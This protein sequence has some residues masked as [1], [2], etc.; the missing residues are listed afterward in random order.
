MK[1]RPSSR[2]RTPPAKPRP[3]QAEGREPREQPRSR[4]NERFLYGIHAVAAA[5]TN[6]ERV[7]R[8]LVVTKGAV[9]ALNGAF[10]TARELGLK[11]PA[12][13]LAERGELD[14]LLPGAVHQGM[15]LDA[16]PLEEPSLS[17]IIAA[18]EGIPASL[19][20]LD[21][22]TDPHN[23]GAILRSA[24]A[25]GARAVITTRHNAPEITG[26]LAKTA[27]G[28][29]EDVPYVKV[30]NLVRA[31]E[32]L[33]DEGFITIALDERGEKPLAQHAPFHRTV[34]I[35]GAEGE[36]LRRLTLETSQFKA[37]LPT[38]GPVGSLNVSN[39]AAV[40]LYELGRG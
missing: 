29:V 32:Q 20:V 33:M 31:L 14:R 24:S 16:E 12:P 19:L 4:A 30:P 7:C 5:W 13:T 21:Q 18:C 15:A 22:I 2:P 6:P 34:L 25:F 36:G 39:A 37:K 23:L 38:G 10:R 35:L 11:R 17:D 3:H 28:A 9:E 26:V 27:S 40:A 1:P 8:R